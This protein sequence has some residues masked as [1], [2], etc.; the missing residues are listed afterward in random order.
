MSKLPDPTYWLSTGGAA[1]GPYTAPQIVRMFRAGSIPATAQSCPVGSERWGAAAELVRHE[2]GAAR[3]KTL[4][5][6][7]LAVVGLIVSGLVIKEFLTIAN[8]EQFT[9]EFNAKTFEEM[10]LPTGSR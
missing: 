8:Q 1:E 9:R 10:G 2:T 6:V 7:A 5:C 4:V 3:L